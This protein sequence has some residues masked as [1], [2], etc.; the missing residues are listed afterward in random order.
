MY[1]ICNKSSKHLKIINF[2]LNSENTR[3]CDGLC[4][5]LNNIKESPELAYHI[6]EKINWHITL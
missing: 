4:F 3:V 5:K 2:T 1:L 6:E